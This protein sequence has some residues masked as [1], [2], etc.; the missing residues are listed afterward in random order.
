MRVLFCSSAY[1]FAAEPEV[2][3]F[4]TGCV[5]GREPSHPQRRR[6]P[7]S[8]LPPGA[9]PTPHGGAFSA[10]SGLLR[11]NR[12]RRLNLQLV[13]PPRSPAASIFHRQR[14]VRFEGTGLFLFTATSRGSGCPQDHARG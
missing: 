1:V 6:S 14:P 2:G 12:F 10:A 5:I 11:S 4:K 8:C 7:R 3:Y 9:I 13:S